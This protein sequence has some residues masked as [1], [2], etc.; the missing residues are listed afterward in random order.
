MEKAEPV[1]V[2]LYCRLEVQVGAPDA[3]VELAVRRLREADIDWSAEPDTLDEAIAELRGDLPRALAGLVDPDGPLAGV[4]GVEVLRGRCWAEIG[5][6][7]ERFR[8]GPD[9]S[10]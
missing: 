4:P 7:S 9:T 2:Q 6:P 5:A 8:P 10:G 3:V 1:V